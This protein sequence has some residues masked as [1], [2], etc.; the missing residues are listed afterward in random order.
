MNGICLLIFILFYSFIRTEQ[1]TCLSNC[2]NKYVKHDGS[3]RLD[4]CIKIISEICKAQIIAYY[5]EKTFPRY[6][7]YTYGFVGDIQEEKHKKFVKHYG[8]I[9]LTEYQFIINAKK[10]ETIIIAD[11]YCRENNDCISIRIEQLFKKYNQQINPFYN[12]KSFIYSDIY[13]SK[14]ICYESTMFNIK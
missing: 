10:S 2:S 5:N 4:N 13:P 1:L 7:N 8:L 9:N 14:L 3:I 11:I 12:L 6:Y